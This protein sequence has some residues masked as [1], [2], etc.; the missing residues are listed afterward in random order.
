MNNGVVLIVHDNGTVD[1][2]ALAILS[3]KLVKKHLKV[4]VSIITDENTLGNLKQKIDSVESFY[5]KII[6]IDPPIKNNKRVIFHGDNYKSMSFMNQTRS[7]IWEL[8]PYERTLLIDVDYLI[9]SD[10][11]SMYWESS[12][13]FL[14]ASSAS[15]VLNKRLGILDK[16]ISDTGPHMYWATTV[17]FTKNTRTKILFDLIEYIK[18]N[19]L[20]FSE[21]YKFDTRTFR[22]DIA[23]SLA[24]HI[25][26]GFISP[27]GQCLPAVLT[28]FDKDLLLNIKEKSLKFMIHDWNDGDILI[29]ISDRDIH[30]IN[31][32]TILDNYSSLMELA[33]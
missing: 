31:K 7:S 29:D 22:N 18:E 32:Q 33:E 9:F 4:P 27:S 17:M 13:D 8:T 24:K 25:I 6:L 16:R 26:D 30:F 23:F 15:E 10:N 28:M 12:E 5:D 14:I 21:I 11:L 20:Y 1:Y 3:A 19:Y 2:S